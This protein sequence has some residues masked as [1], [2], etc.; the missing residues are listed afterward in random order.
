MDKEEKYL[1]IPKEKIRFY[2]RIKVDKDTRQ[3]IKLVNYLQKWGLEWQKKH[4]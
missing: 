3:L 4:N 1:R 2:R